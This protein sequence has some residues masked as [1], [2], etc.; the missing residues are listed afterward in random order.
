MGEFVIGDTDFGIDRASVIFDLVPGDDG[1]VLLTVEFEGREVDFDR[2]Q[3]ER[4]DQWGWASYP[5]SFYLRD[6]PVAA[7]GAGTITTVLDRK[8]YQQ[9]EVALYMMEHN[10]VEGSI[11]ITAGT[12]I[13]IIGQVDLMGKLTPFR[14]RW[15]K[16][17]A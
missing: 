5:P 14:I 9:Y 4:G 8:A 3:E 15:S 6:F 13:E 17:E 2:I 7:A 16:P 10:T 11:N 12:Q 1:T